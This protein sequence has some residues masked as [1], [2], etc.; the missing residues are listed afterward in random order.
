M[1]WRALHIG[2]AQQCTRYQDTL[3]GLSHFHH[4]VATDEPL[5]HHYFLLQICLDIQLLNPALIPDVVRLTA[6]TAHVLLRALIEREKSSNFNSSTVT[7]AISRESS[8]MS[9]LTSG[10]SSSSAKSSSREGHT[11]TNPKRVLADSPVTNLLRTETIHAFHT[12][13]FDR[14]PNDDPYNAGSY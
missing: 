2:F 12:T 9:T 1:C 6:A 8:D 4:G 13:T 7:A 5:A 3:R 10:T 11:L 14:R